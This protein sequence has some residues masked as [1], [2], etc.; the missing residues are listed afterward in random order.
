M[1]RSTYTNATEAPVFTQVESEVIYGLAS[2]GIY[3][4]GS[5]SQIEAGQ[6][7]QP[8]RSWMLPT[9]WGV[10]GAIAARC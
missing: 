10:N 9:S 3:L 1:V 8:T 6:S 2:Q 7:E 5:E 4:E